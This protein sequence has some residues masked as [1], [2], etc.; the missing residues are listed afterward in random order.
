MLAP[1]PHPQL[2]P[3]RQRRAKTRLFLGFA[4]L[5]LLGAVGW[6]LSLNNIISSLWASIFSA[7]FAILGVL[8]SLVQT[9]VQSSSEPEVSGTN[10]LG[11][12]QT[13][14]SR[15]IHMKDEKLGANRQKGALVIYTG[16]R[17]RG[18]TISLCEGF[19]THPVDVIDATNVVERTINGAEV[20]S[21]IFP[22]LEPG[23]YTVFSEQ[24]KLVAMTSV[25]AS[26][27]A[28]VDWR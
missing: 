22:A 11:R 28:E 12:K 15:R 19:H 23:K 4:V 20:F 17:L 5:I 7:I 21:G 1:T 14:S 18:S 16:K 24:R 2:Q 9:H 6:L 25:Y 10:P 26:S 13:Q 3:P 27:V 8:L